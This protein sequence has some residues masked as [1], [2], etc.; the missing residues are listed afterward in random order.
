[1]FIN[2][3]RTKGKVKDFIPYSGSEMKLLLEA[4]VLRK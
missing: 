2:K 4:I 1:M 3:I